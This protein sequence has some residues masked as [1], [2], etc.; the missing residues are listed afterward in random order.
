MVYFDA[1][2]L[3]LP[4]CVPSIIKPEFDFNDDCIVN[5][6]D[7]NVVVFDWLTID[8]VDVSPPDGNGLLV[9]YTFDTDYSDTSGNG[10]DG[11]PG[12][13][14]SIS[15]GKLVLNGAL[16][17][18][19]ELSYVDIPLGQA[20]PFAGTGDYSIQMTF[21]STNGSGFLLTSAHPIKGGDEDNSMAF[22]TQKQQGW[23]NLTPVVHILHRGELDQ[24]SIVAFT[25][26]M[27]H[28]VVVTYDALRGTM[29]YYDDGFQDR[30]WKVRYGMVWYDEHVVRIGGCGSH[31][32]RNEFPVKDS[33]IGE[34]DSVRIYNYALSE[35]EAMYLAT[36]GMGIRPMLSPANLYDEE[37]P[38]SKAVNFRDFAILAD[39]WLEKFY[40]P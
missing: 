17:Y 16:F 19:A 35:S 3:Y 32:A 21:R 9:E 18:G 23:E 4:R 20:N 37:P 13:E 24:E 33:F 10:Y 28:T 27:M 11:L 6:K 5:A 26:G 2:R 29:R 38:G 7:V 22:Y 25:D 30:T 15:D 39:R 1:I 36:D 40:W 14:A 8:T 31:G 12:P 34:I